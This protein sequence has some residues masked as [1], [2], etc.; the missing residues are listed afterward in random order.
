MRKT[1]SRRLSCSWPKRHPPNGGSRQSPVGYTE[2]LTC[3]A[4]KVRRS[5]A[6]RTRHEGRA[7][8]RASAEPARRNH[9]PGTPRQFSTRNCSP[10]P[11]CSAAPSWCATS[12]GPRG[13]R[14]PKRLGCPLSTL[15]KRLERG[16]ARLHDALV[17]R[18]LGLPAALLGTILAEQSAAADTRHTD[19]RNGRARP[20]PGHWECD[21]RRSFSSGYP[22]YERRD[23]YDGLEQT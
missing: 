12:R 20:G 13:T 10:C 5:T 1:S 21:R 9:R 14:R 18:G 3:C 11:N 4:L 22:T 23:R 8:A 6:R 2:P 15:K 7:P 16:R 17:R 19:S